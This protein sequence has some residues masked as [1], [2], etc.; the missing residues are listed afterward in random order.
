MGRSAFERRGEWLQTGR[1]ARGHRTGHF[2]PAENRYTVAAFAAEE[3][4][5]TRGYHMERCV[6]SSL[7]VDKGRL[8]AWTALLKEGHPWLD[9]SSMQLDGSQTFAQKQGEYIGY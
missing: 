7:R 4:L 9:L 2:S 5:R 3:V 6:L 8:L 1:G